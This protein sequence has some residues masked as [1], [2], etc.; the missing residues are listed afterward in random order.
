MGSEK[1]VNTESCTAITVTIKT[2]KLLYK[3]K[4]V[5]VKSNV[6]E[7]QD[8]MSITSVPSDP[9]KRKFIVSLNAYVPGCTLVIRESAPSKLFV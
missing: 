6:T 8:P 4:A 3:F 9:S 1:K 7:L 5:L 2:A